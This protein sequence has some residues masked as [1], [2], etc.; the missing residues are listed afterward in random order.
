MP[1]KQFLNPWVMIIA[2]LVVSCNRKI[3]HVAIRDDSTGQITAVILSPEETERSGI[4]YGPISKLVVDK[5]ISCSGYLVTLPGST[6]EVTAPAAGKITSIIYPSGHFVTSGSEIADL[7][8]SDFILLKQA[9]LEAVNEYDFL[10]EEYARQGELTVENATSLK[11][12]Q[13]AKRD[14]QSAELKLQALLSQLE[15]LGI[16]PDSL[17]FNKMSPVIQIRTPGKGYISNIRVQPGSYVGKGETLFELINTRQLLVKLEVPEQYIR[18]IQKGQF[19]DFWLV[20]DTLSIFK[21]QVLSMAGAIN[22]DNHSI[23]VFA[24]LS[25]IKPYFIP[26]MSIH[27]KINA[28]KDTTI[29]IATSIIGHSP[30]GDFLFVRKNGNYAKIPIKKGR[31]IGEMT[32]VFGI[33]HSDSVVINGADYLYPLFDLR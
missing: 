20:H 26:G 12:M 28:N 3:D 15:I 4:K 2:M 27:A 24:E 6:I 22:R 21:A 1:S 32:E 19:V 13:L 23:T 14:Y 18:F 33:Q 16:S 8:N 10:H 31:V 5:W 7:E 29:V 17:R 11:K 30:E 25:D 9:Y